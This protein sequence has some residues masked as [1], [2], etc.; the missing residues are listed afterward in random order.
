MIK[1]TLSDTRQLLI[2]GNATETLQFCFDDWI[3]T[4]QKAIQKKGA[5]FVALSGGSTPK[6]LFTKLANEAKDFLNWS[7]VYFFWSDERAVPPTNPESN[8]H[9]AMTEAA[10]DVLKV[11]HVYRMTAEQSIEENALAYEKII[12]KKMHNHSFDLIM[13]GLGDDGHTASLFPHTNALHETSRFVVANEV[14]QKKCFR[15][16]FTYP[17][18]NQANKICFYV[19]GASK[20]FILEK[21]L[22]GPFLPNDYPSQKIGTPTH[23]AI[24]IID[25]AAATRVLAHI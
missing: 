16:T 7:K 18:I 8:Y 21:I 23:P 13:L 14:P 3:D 24:F 9:M 1:T 12:K 25:Q 17:L 22:F 19:M 11:K 4:A 15:M 5:F 10:L 2:P 20:S 6:A